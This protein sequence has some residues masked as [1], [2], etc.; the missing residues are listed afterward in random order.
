MI[1]KTANRLEFLDGLSDAGKQL[2]KVFLEHLRKR[3]P[4]ESARIFKPF[5][6]LQLL[7]EGSKFPK[8]DV[9]SAISNLVKTCKPLLGTGAKA[10]KKSLY[11]DFL[12][13]EAY[14]RKERVACIKKAASEAG[15][16][17]R[18]SLH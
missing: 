12:L 11:K 14:A 15:V 16:G 4:L 7:V 9:K 8:R 10:D 3:L 6:F 13:T 5:E 1:E 2:R 18:F 17:K